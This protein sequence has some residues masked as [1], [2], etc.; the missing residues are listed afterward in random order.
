MKFFG[1]A[2]LFIL[3][4]IH[5]NAQQVVH[6]ENRRMK[7]TDTGFHG[8][9]DF[10]LNLTQNLNDILN[11][12]GYLHLHYGLE[13]QKFF[14][15]TNY[16]LTL[17]NNNPIVDDFFQHLRYN[18]RVNKIVTMEAFTQYSYNRIVKFDPRILAGAGPRFRI[19]ANDSLNQR[20]YVGTLF[21]REYEEETTGI[22]NRHTRFSGYVSFGFN[23]KNARVDL[24]TYYQPDILDFNDFRSSTRL[25]IELPITNKLSF[26]VAHNI[27]YDSRPPEGIRRTWFVLNHGLKYRFR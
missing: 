26:N 24:V 5:L 19:F 2:I 20:L 21:F 6:V 18:Y 15:I 8:S 25:N 16:N 4:S 1:F 14:S 13:K 10:N 9:M 12:N 7:Y 27:V 3:L 17:F 22:I 11:S 23:I